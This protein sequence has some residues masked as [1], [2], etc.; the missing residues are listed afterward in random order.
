M[1]NIEKELKLALQY[2]EPYWRMQNNYQDYKSSFIYDAK[3][4]EEV[5]TLSSEYGIDVKY[6]IHRWYN[7]HTSLRCEYIFTEFGAVKDKNY[8]NK[9]IDIYINDVPFDVK[10]TV[11]PM[12]LKEHPFNL[13]KREGKN[14][15]I[16]WFY[17]HQ[18]QEG[19]MHMLNRLFIVCDGKTQKESL[20]LK[21]DFDIIREKI[22]NYMKVV[23][24]KGL[25]SVT[26]NCKGKEYTV[27]S[28][29]IYIT[30]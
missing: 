26:F 8:K 22:G 7:F 9:E 20:A 6:A 23:N 30:K 4:F 19:R 2:I 18:S 1:D 17:I 5:I 13:R 11:Y 3:T 12:A 27:N 21:C 14:K 24:E 16:E 15:M 29:I 10:L 25:N 28:D